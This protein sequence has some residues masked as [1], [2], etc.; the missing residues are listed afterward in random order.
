MMMMATRSR[1]RSQSGLHI[2]PPDEEQEV[3]APPY[4]KRDENF[5]FYFFWDE[6]QLIELELA[7]AGACGFHKPAHRHQGG[8]WRSQGLWPTCPPPQVELGTYIF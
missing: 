3:A 8:W 1:S 5:S 6:R 2:C 7:A 4:R